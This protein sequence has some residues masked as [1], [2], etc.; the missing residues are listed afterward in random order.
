MN[1]APSKSPRIIAII[2]ARGGSKGIPRKNV[3]PLCGKPLIGWTIEAARAA[4]HVDRVV[5][6]TDDSEIASVSKRFGADVVWRPEEISGDLASSEDAL[7]HVLEH[8]EQSEG[9]RPEIVVFL[10]CTSPLT[11]AKDIDGTVEIVLNG[12]ADTALATVP[13][14]YFLWKRNA[15]GDSVGINHDKSI[16]ML[17]QE[18]EPQFLE[19][20]AVYVMRADG[21]R[22]A[23]ARFFSRTAMYVMPAERCWEID[24]PV[25]FQIAEVLL[26]NRLRHHRAELLPE[27]I[28]A[29]V[30]DFDGVFT[31]NRVV[32]LEDGREAVFCS[33]GDGMGISLLRSTAVKM[34]VISTEKNP[35]VTARCRKLNLECLSG[36]D[37]KLVALTE[38]ANRNGILL[39][40]VVYVGNDVNDLTCLEAVGCGVVPSDAHPS[41]MSS[42][43]IVLEHGGGGGAVREVADLILGKVS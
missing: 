34:L 12:Q 28:E 10:Q 13:F 24:D 42:A 2:P 29:V 8:L 1:S 14:H 33:R 22:R 18:T 26:R 40:K 38:W 16:R 11:A 3:L 6:S 35:V 31:D 19:T 21:F 32:V 25:D 30:F 9:C 20:G 37:D 23:K 43:R 41:I 4:R 7:L 36:V 5:V 15:Q 27:T 39:E 17:R